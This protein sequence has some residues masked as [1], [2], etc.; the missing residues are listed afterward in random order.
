MAVR[1]A[2]F[3]ALGAF[4]LS[5]CAEQPSEPAIP[6]VETSA[7]EAPVRVLIDAVTRNLE[8]NRQSA[9][10]WGRLGRVYHAH[11]LYARLAILDSLVSSIA[12]EMG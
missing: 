12:E 7:M 6:S 3:F 8:G 5:G 10:A 2:G 1:I 11:E 9:N 4:V